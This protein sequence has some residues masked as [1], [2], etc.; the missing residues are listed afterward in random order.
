ML[1]KDIKMQLDSEIA[2]VK[3]TLRSIESL[4]K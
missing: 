3:E 4:L 1:K 2:D